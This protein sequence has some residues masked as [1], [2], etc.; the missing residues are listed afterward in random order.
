[1]RELHD[2]AVAVQVSQHHLVNEK[3]NCQ[4][5]ASRRALSKNLRC[6]S[7]LF[8]ILLRDVVSASE[9]CRSTGMWFSRGDGPWY[10]MVSKLGTRVRS[11]CRRAI[12]KENNL[13]SV[14]YLS[15]SVHDFS[16]CTGVSC[17]AGRRDSNFASAVAPVVEA[18]A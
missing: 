2:T 10:R 1:M 13:P 7:K 8:N 11:G 18:S 12:S 14:A 3:E 9:F 4:S 16:K 5:A 6:L 17:S 15:F